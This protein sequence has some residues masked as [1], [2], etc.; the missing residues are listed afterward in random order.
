VE[1]KLG[2]VRLDDGTSVAY[3]TVGTGPALL[4]AP[5]WVSHLELDWALTPQRRFLEA[6]ARG[7]TLI[8]YDRPGCGL[9]DAAPSSPALA[10]LEIDVIG[11][12]TAGVGVRRFDLVGMSLSAA[13]AA[14]WAAARPETVRRLVLYGGWADGARLGPAEVREHVLGLVE[15]H[16]G[17]GSQV[18]TEIFAPE[19]GSAFRASFAALQREAASAPVALQVLAAGYALSVAADLGRVQAPTVVVHR[20]G[21]RAVPLA[22]GER[23]AAGIH[24]AELVVLP[25]RSHIPAVGDADGVVDAIRAGLGLAR[26]RRRFAPELTPRQWEVAALVAR[27]MSNR[28]IARELTITERSAESHVE[29][30]RDRLGLRSRAQLAARYVTSHE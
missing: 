21:D 8:R 18:L 5:G 30:I 12:V 29:R 27:G 14:R 26:V 23:L 25:G 7:R 22:E 20:E 6:L 4:L 16:W 3:S 13:L 24:G 15:K 1:Q 10:D 11:A 17:L 9:S 2:R 19:A 28:E